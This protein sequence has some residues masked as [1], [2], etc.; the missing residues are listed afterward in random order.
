[1]PEKTELAWRT[2]CLQYNLHRASAGLIVPQSRMMS[3]RRSNSAENGGTI[4]LAMLGA[5]LHRVSWSAE[6]LQ[7]S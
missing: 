6:T 7:R 4:L 1:M 5:I 3:R 2:V